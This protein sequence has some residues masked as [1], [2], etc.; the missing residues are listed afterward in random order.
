MILFKQLMCSKVDHYNHRYIIR[1]KLY[2][3][4]V[5]SGNYK[6]V[7]EILQDKDIIDY[8]PYFVVKV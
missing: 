1:H 8:K 4:G 6:F 5:I 3:T 7:A 2:G